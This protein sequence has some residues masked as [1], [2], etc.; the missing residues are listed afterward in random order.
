MIFFIPFAYHSLCSTAPDTATAEVVTYENIKT[1]ILLDTEQD[2]S[3]IGTK[4]K[5]DE[6]GAAD[7]QP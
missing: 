7:S 5:L 6:A 2:F 1:S 4:I 3:V